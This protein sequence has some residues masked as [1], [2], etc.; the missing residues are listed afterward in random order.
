MIL[1]H[2]VYQI[3]G[4]FSAVSLVNKNRS[5]LQR[6]LKKKYRVIFDKSLYELTEIMKH[7]ATVE[8]AMNKVLNVDITGANKR[9]SAAGN[10][11]SYS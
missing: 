8:H 6:N 1:I 3:G 5:W 2:Y 11:R 10:L 9:H 4:L 7:T